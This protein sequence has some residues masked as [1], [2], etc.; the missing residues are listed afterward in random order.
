MKI[1]FRNKSWLP[2]LSSLPRFGRFTNF[3]FSL[4][5]NNIYIYFWQICGIQKR[6]GMLLNISLSDRSD[7]GAASGRTSFVG[8]KKEQEEGRER[9]ETVKEMG[10]MLREIRNW[11]REDSHRFLPP[12]FFFLFG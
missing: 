1:R 5:T 6:C 8:T 4:Q 9:G 7:S 2:F 10:F 12:P 3:F 11:S